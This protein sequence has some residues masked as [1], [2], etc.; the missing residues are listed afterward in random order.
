M[1]HLASGKRHSR[2]LIKRGCRADMFQPIT[3][4]AGKRG[5]VQKDIQI[6]KD[7]IREYIKIVDHGFKVGAKVMLNNHAA[8]KYATL[9]KGAF[10]IS[11]CWTNVMVTLQC[12]KTKIRYNIRRIKQYKSDTNIEDIKPET[13]D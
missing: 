5:N 4:T 12:G 13:N 7:N 11:H 8:Y 6:N 9:Y 2:L 3:I 1:E 10:L